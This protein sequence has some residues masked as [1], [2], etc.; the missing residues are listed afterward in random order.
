MSYQRHYVKV[1]AATVSAAVSSKAGAAVGATRPVRMVCIGNMLG[2]YQP[3]FFP[4]KIGRGYDF[5][6]LLQPMAP[7]QNDFT[8]FSGLAHTQWRTLSTRLLNSLA[9]SSMSGGLPVP[10]TSEDGS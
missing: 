1:A 10:R 2:F 4:K 8:L 5:P 7:H 6:T 3:E 9:N